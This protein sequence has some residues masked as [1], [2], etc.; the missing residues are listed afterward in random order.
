MRCADPDAVARIVRRWL[1]ALDGPT[2][3]AGADAFADPVGAR[4]RAGIGGI[5][6]EVLGGLDAGRTCRHLD[7]I[8]RVRGAQERTPAQAVAFVFDLREILLEESTLPPPL[9][10]HRVDQIALWAFDVYARCREEVFALRLRELRSPLAL[11]EP[12][13]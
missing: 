4:Y 11:R 6:E 1:A 2:A 3:A 5:A 7:E 8:L 12:A 10:H 9:V 13:P